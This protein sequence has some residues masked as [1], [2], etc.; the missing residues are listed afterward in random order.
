MSDNHIDIQMDGHV[1]V[2]R[3]TN[4]K[5]RNALSPAMRDGLAKAIHEAADDHTVR[6]L[7]ITGSGKSFCAGGDFDTLSKFNDSWSTH[8]RFRHMSAFIA[9]MIRMPK[10]I[11][12]GVNGYAVG[13]GMGLALAGD[14]IFAAES[15]KF[16]AG[17]MRL[18][19]MPDYGTMY[20]LP[21]LVGMARAKNFLFSNGTWT[22]AE[23]LQMGLVA[24]VLPDDELDAVAL[25]HAHELAAGPVEAMG[26]TKMIM[27]RSFEQSAEEMLAFEALGQPLAFRTEAFQEGFGAARDKAKADFPAASDREFWHLNQGGDKT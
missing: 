3:F 18:G 4:D 13:G 7:Y 12:I 23:A 2:I 19:A 22:A 6:A 27:G 26:I 16:M 1:L 20:S 14:V 15:A 8:N 5:M 17:F 21:R 9:Q 10:P 24:G 25:K 11:V